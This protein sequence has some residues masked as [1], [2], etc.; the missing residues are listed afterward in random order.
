MD[1]QTWLYFLP[2]RRLSLTGF[3]QPTPEIS[4]I[5]VRIFCLYCDVF[6]SLCVCNIP[7]SFFLI[8]WLSG[9]NFLTSYYW[10][11][12]CLL[13]FVWLCNS[14]LLDVLCKICFFYCY[15]FCV[16][17]LFPDTIA[18]ISFPYPFYALPMCDNSVEL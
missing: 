11:L 2:F 18:S 14:L 13:K 9:W 5:F 17:F 12:V 10:M 6:V 7:Q 15:A 1:T 8:V 4:F 3:K 16:T